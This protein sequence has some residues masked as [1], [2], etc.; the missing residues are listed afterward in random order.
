MDVT[1][2][3]LMHAL[4]GMQSMLFLMRSSARAVYTYHSGEDYMQLISENLKIP[5]RPAAIRE[6]S[7][8]LSEMELSCLFKRA[9]PA[10]AMS[11]TKFNVACLSILIQ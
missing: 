11:K 8:F 5:G 2:S 1:S 7:V 9:S 6:G 10:R 3:L 4:S